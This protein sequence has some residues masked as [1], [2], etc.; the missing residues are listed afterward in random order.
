[1]L[2]LPI[3]DPIKLA[4]LDPILIR[5][6]IDVPVITSFGVISERTSL[7]IRA[8]DTD[9]AVGWGRFLEIFLFM[10]Q[11]IENISLRTTLPHWR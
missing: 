1:M 11:K 4:T 2:R 10:G 9:G 5:A 7:L 3:T 8:E 6:K